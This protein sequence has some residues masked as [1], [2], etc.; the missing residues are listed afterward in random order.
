MEK[1]QL[2]DRDGFH[3][4]CEYFP[5]VPDVLFIHC[6]VDGWSPSKYKHYLD[7]WSE[8]VDVL[9]NKGIVSVKVLIDNDELAKFASMFGFEYQVQILTTDD[10]LY[11]IM[12]ME[13]D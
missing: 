11:D 7:L 3:L 5:E 6:E 13:I 2:L 12:S 4:T 8:T 1:R 10:K 9:K